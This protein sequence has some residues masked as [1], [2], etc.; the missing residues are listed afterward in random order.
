MGGSD[1]GVEDGGAAAALV[2]AGEEII[3]AAQGQ[4]LDGPLGGVVREFEAPVLDE[5][6]QSGLT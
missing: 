2:G 6:H 4:G 1:Q 3:F 5:V